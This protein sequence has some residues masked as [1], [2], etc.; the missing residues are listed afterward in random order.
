[1][2]AAERLL[3]MCTLL[4]GADVKVRIRAWDGSEAGP[5][6][7]MCLDVRSR[8]AVRRLLHQ[9]NQLGLGR[10]YVAG[11]IDVDSDL[12]EILEQFEAVVIPTR[13]S[14]QL[15][16]IDSYVFPD[17][18]LSPIGSTVSVLEN[19][20]FEVR[21]DEALRERYPRTLRAWAHNL[22]EHWDEAVAL[23]GEGRAR[24]W[25]LYITA[26]AL[27][28]EQGNI[29]LHQVLAVRPGLDGHSGMP[30]MRQD[31]LGVR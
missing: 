19:S 2:D 27:S 10:A 23:V 22:D 29:G 25:R 13:S 20:G 15:S 31:W 3:Q 5:A 24:V 7:A 18:D 21:D 6:G 4:L 30:P 26:S 8:Q 17:S 9:L 28:F 11:E 1:M 16:F 12:F 14:S